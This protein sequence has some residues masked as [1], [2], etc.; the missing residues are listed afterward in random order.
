MLGWYADQSHVAHTRG[1]L[2]G[3]FRGSGGA[4]LACT[5]VDHP[6]DYTFLHIERASLVWVPSLWI[7]P[8]ALFLFTFFC[9]A[10]V[11]VCWAL[12]VG[13]LPNC[14]YCACFTGHTPCMLFLSI[15]FMYLILCIYFYF[16]KLEI[17]KKIYL[18]LT[19][20]KLK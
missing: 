7:D 20:T 11:F 10:V 5:C 19:K 4:C 14:S 15:L 18:F 17:N 2:I 1:L 9:L 3:Y 13:P 8:L 12:L 6:L 16:S